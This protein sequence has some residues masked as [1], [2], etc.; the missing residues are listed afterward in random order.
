MFNKSTLPNSSYLSHTHK[1]G[2]PWRRS[3]QAQEQHSA[4]EGVLAIHAQPVTI[5][6]LAYT[7]YYLVIRVH[8]TRSWSI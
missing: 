2:S 4:T 3:F 8:Y 7:H 1:G 6:T 5:F